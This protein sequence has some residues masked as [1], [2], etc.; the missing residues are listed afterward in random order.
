[1]DVQYPKRYPRLED[2]KPANIWPFYQ[3]HVENCVSL[4]WRFL[5]WVLYVTKGRV[6]CSMLLHPFSSFLVLRSFETFPSLNEFYVTDKKNCV[7]FEPLV[8]NLSTVILGL[9][10]WGDLF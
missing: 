1:M 9:F 10:H 8:F 4:G 2:H 7:S 6:G 3:L 5:G